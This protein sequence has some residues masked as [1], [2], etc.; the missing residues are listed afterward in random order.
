MV[1]ALISSVCPWSQVVGIGQCHSDWQQAESNGIPPTLSSHMWNCQDSN[2]KSPEGSRRSFCLLIY[3][4]FTCKLVPSFY[5]WHFR[6]TT[7]NLSALGFLLQC[8]I[9]DLRPHISY[10]ISPDLPISW[11]ISSSAHSTG[12]LRGLGQGIVKTM[13]RCSLNVLM[14]QPSCSFLAAR[15]WFWFWCFIESMM[16]CFQTMFAEPSEV[17]NITDPPPDP[18]V[19]IRFF[20][21]KTSLSGSLFK[22]N[23]SLCA[24]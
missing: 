11:V 21:V 12:L 10:R 2:L 24:A 17:H 8:L 13:I 19:R 1:F 3:L 23:P 6:L 5:L 15:F 14:E 7:S 22:P 20:S 16:P 9:S 18:T 4:F